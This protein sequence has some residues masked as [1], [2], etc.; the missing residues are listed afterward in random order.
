MA[1]LVSERKIFFIIKNRITV[2]EGCLG[3]QNTGTESLPLNKLLRNL[4]ARSTQ[5]IAISL[6]PLCFSLPRRLVKA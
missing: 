6:L 4:L 2:K 5:L 3:I 1:Y